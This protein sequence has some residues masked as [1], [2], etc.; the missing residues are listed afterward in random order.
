ME[1]QFLLLTL[2]LALASATKL[3]LSLQSYDKQCFYEI[4]RTFP[5]TSESQQK[6]SFDVSPKIQGKYEVE[7]SN[8][9]D[10]QWNSVYYKQAK[11]VLE[12]LNVHKLALTDSTYSFCVRNVGDDTI[13]V[14]VNI[15]SGLELME[16]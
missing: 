3:T 6:Y 5:L 16:F 4:L 14:S 8:M 11:N 7:V 9:I 15:Q 1:K 2:V 10:G 12:T 13:K